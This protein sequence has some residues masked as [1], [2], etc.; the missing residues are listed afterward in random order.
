MVLSLSQ[1]VD[2]LHCFA[3]AAVEQSFVQFSVGAVLRA[4]AEFDVAVGSVA[5]IAAVG[6]AVA[7]GSEFV[8]TALDFQTHLV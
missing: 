7:G 5:D 3:T 8:E 4:V 1:S 6:D 2:A